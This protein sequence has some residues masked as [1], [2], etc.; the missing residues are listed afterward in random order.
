MSP[1]LT[2]FVPTIPGRESLLSRCLWSLSQVPD[3]RCEILVVHGPGK[4]GDKYDTAVGAATG[5]MF[6]M[7]DDDDWVAA[8]YATTVCDMIDAEGGDMVGYLVA[9]LMNGRYKFTISHRFGGS[10]NWMR[11]LDRGP[12]L[13][14]PT[15][16]NI[17]RQVP[18]GNEYDADQRWML[19]VAKL[20][21]SGSF[22]DRHMYMHD[23][24]AGQS[25]FRDRE[26]GSIGTWPFNPAQF[27]WVE[28]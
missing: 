20:V 26:H 7:I 23:Y 17:V 14:V 18:L 25:A 13:K 3:E 16:T 22:I 1:V 11:I 28:G 9:S 12:S 6:V 27:R 4:L 21:R 5:D 2:V 19:T 8:D 10:T 15:S 24:W